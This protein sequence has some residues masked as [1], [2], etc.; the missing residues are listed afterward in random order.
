M[1]IVPGTPVELK[2]ASVAGFSGGLRPQPELV[3]T[4]IHKTG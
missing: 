3:T 1:W 2:R 4:S